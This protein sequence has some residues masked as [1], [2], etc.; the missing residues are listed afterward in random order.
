MKLTTIKIEK[1]KPI[2]GEEKVSDGNGL[3]IRF[4]KTADGKVSK[5]WHFRYQVNGKSHYLVIGAYDAAISDREAA[6]YKLDHGAKLSLG[7][8]RKI[9]LE[10]TDWCKRGLN[11]KQY[12]DEEINRQKLELEEG[13]KK[14][15]IAAKAE[16]IENLTFA[17]LYEIWLRDGV[18]RKDGNAELRRSFHADILPEIGKK[19]IKDLSE[20]D[21][22]RVLR[23]MVDRGVNRT[24]VIA[25]NNL[26]QM[27]AW[28]EKRQPWRRL[29]AEGNPADLIEIEKIVST[30]YDLN[31]VR[32]RV[33]SDTEIHELQNIFLKMEADYTN[34]PNRR[35]TD[36][37]FESVGQLAVWIMLSTL[38]RV[39]ELMQTRWQHIDFD[40]KEW[41]I[42]KE[43]VKGRIS[44]HKVYL[45]DFSTQQFQ[46]LYQLTGKFEW[47]FPAKHRDGH[48][49][50]KSLAKQIGDRQGRFKKGKDGNPR[51]PMKNRRHDDSL[52]LDDGENGE[53]TLHDLRRT[54]ATIMQRLGIPIEIIDRCQNHVIKG[55]KVGRHYLH[56]DYAAEKQHA[57]EKLGQHLQAILENPSKLMT[58]K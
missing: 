47:C 17:D 35:S 11:P 4:R 7:N 21:L 43:N 13:R 3:T 10:L 40:K 30:E 55:S 39:G 57:W 56:H 53:W 32:E 46:R 31:N 27:L 33:L 44:S 38:C 48:V 18:R 19:K 2:R 50:L 36:K 51:Q 41:H 26:V 8:A 24:A 9:A 52:V 58:S 45:S 20:H 1:Y 5:H 6:I 22:R 14:A 29:M 16:Q 54:G 28:A 23:K 34:A 49:C 37:P 42:P 25:R 12:I 15:E